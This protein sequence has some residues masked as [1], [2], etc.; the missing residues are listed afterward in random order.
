MLY[1]FIY[2]VG[3]FLTHGFFKYYNPPRADNADDHVSLIVAG[4]FWPVTCFGWFC[5]KILSSWTTDVA[6]GIIKFFTPKPKPVVT[7]IRVA[8]T[9]EEKYNEAMEQRETLNKEIERLSTK[10]GVTKVFR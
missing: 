2:L 3:F 5:Y 7:S 9:D 6:G 8:V 1:L 4:F 10:L